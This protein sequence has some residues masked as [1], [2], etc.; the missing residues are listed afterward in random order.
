MTVFNKREIIE[1]LLDDIEEEEICMSLLNTHYQD[2]QE[3]LFFDE[4]Q[5]EKVSH[6]LHRM[7]SDS[8]RHKGM[9]MKMISLLEKMD[10]GA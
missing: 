2:R 5:R 10:D 8:E 1:K 9:I 4:P 7:A 6:I 3:L